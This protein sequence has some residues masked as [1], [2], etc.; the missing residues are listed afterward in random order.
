MEELIELKEY[1]AFDLEFNTVDGQTDI[2]QVSAVK[3]FDHKEVASFDSLVYTDKPLFGFINGLTGITKEMVE[4][5]PKLQDVMAKFN[6][7]VGEV[8]LIGYNAIESDLPLL[9]AAG[10][11][12]SEK[13][14]LDVFHTVKALRST[15]LHGIKN[16]QL[17]TVAEYFGVK[18]RGHN[19]LEDARMTA[20]VYEALLENEANKKLAQAQ[21]ETHAT[22]G[23]FDGVDLSAFFD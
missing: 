17:T 3:L 23:L 2:I 15:D 10:L 11:D 13:Y 12:L 6:A 5:A 20:L 7:F 22:N 9:T 4:T 19:S 8:P 21:E 16:L 18:G 14:A 1:I